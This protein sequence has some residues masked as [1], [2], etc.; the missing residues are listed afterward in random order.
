MKRLAAITLLLALLLCACGKPAETPSP[1]P[2]PEVTSPMAPPIPESTPAPEATPDPAPAPGP[3]D[4]PDAQPETTEPPE[5]NEQPEVTPPQTPTPEATP[6]PEVEPE[7]TPEPTPDATPAP[8]LEPPVYPEVE[9]M[10]CFDGIYFEPR[11]AVDDS[12]VNRFAD[13]L[14]ALRDKYFADN[15]VYYAIVPDKSWYFRD[16]TDEYFDHQYIC[17]SL[18]GK[19]EGFTAIDLSGTLS[20]SDYYSTDPH[21][22]QE[23]LSSTVSALADAMGFTYTASAYTANNAGTFIG[24]GLS[25]KDANGAA[26]DTLCYLTSDVINAAV[27]DNFQQQDFKK[28]YDLAK[29][30]TNGYDVFLS[31]AT[32]LTVIETPNA[33]EKRELIIFRDSFG[34][35]IAP[36]M[37]ESYSKVTL[38]DLRYMVSSLLPNYVSF[39][40][41]D[42]LFLYCDELVNSSFLLK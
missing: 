20:G 35:A 2:S 10:L 33:A 16:R 39:N 13:K 8:T 1:A 3:D 41:A 21:W 19:L 18:S 29:L 31:G 25:G 11:P 34:S 27:V 23:N 26:P 36:L 38:V 15:N 28:V 5:Q 30:G 42:V 22:K 7:V 40:N 9:G 32:P 24:T 14:T 12:A 4:I 17:D 6:A 37:L